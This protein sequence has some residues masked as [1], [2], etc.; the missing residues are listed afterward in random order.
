MARAVCGTNHLKLFETEPLICPLLS[1]ISSFAWPL[2]IQFLFSGRKWS[3]E[4]HP[5]TSKI[6][7]SSAFFSP[8]MLWA[9]AFLRPKP[10]NHRLLWTFLECFV[11][12][13]VV[14]FSTAIPS[15]AGA[16]HGQS[17]RRNRRT[18]CRPPAEN[19]SS[20][21]SKRWISEKKPAD[22]GWY[23]M[24]LQLPWKQISQ[25]HGPQ[26]SISICT[27]PL[28]SW[29]EHRRQSD[30]HQ[31]CETWSCIV[32][33]SFSSNSLVS[34]QAVV[35]SEDTGAVYTA[36]RNGAASKNQTISFCDEKAEHLLHNLLEKQHFNIDTNI[37]VFLGTSWVFESCW[38]LSPTACSTHSFLEAIR[39]CLCKS[40]R[41][42]CTAEH[43]K[44]LNVFRSI[45]VWVF[46]LDIG[47]LFHIFHNYQ[48]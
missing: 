16:P 17:H 15:A 24:I 7:P 5:P 9:L 35:N 34:S 42:D 36:W 12:L 11:I 31:I 1:C 25:L 22:S 39:R 20:G 41:C 19:L 23:N 43:A 48:V 30:K 26:L 28:S 21:L 47:G 33:S 32:C 10:R 45:S 46:G 2:A 38:I 4:A 14:M 18:Q 27:L 3:Y 29:K 13:Q 44:R 37:S 8:K 40:R 6:L